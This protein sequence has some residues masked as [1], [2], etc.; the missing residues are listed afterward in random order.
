MGNHQG[1]KLFHILVK[2]LDEVFL[3][4]V[5]FFGGWC[6]FIHWACSIFQRKKGGSW[7]LEKCGSYQ[8]QSALCKYL[9]EEMSMHSAGTGKQIVQQSRW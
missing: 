8:L 6:S 9:H 5:G 7:Y 3:L 4:L 2:G 1:G